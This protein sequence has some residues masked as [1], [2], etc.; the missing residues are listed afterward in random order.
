MSPKKHKCELDLGSD[1]ML[2]K[3]TT[4]LGNCLRNMRKLGQLSKHHPVTATYFGS[5]SAVVAER[6]RQLLE[7]GGRVI[8]PLSVFALIWN[9]IMIIVNLAHM[10]VSTFRL[11]FILR[12]MGKMRIHLADRVL[13]G[14]HALAFLDILVQMNTGYINTKERTTVMVKR[15]TLCHYLRRWFLFDL[16]SSMPLAYFTLKYRYGSR[17][18]LV[19]HILALLRISRIYC[20]HNDLK[21]FLRVFTDSYIV[22]GIVRLAVIFLI[23][24]H[25]CSCIMYLP[26]VV[27]YYWWGVMSKE[28]NYYLRVHGSTDLLLYSWEVRYN[29]AILITLS[30]F[31]GTG[32]TM[33]RSNEPE[34][35]F[36]HAV[37]IVYAAMF[38]IFTLVFLIKSY[39][40]LFGSSLRYHGLM[41]QVEEYMKYRQFPTHLKKRVL[42][43]YQYRYQDRYFKE[44]A[45]LNCLSEELRDEIKLHTCHT[46]VHKVKL[47]EG[48]PPSVVG[49]VL[50]CLHP[51][52]YLS[53]DLVVRAGDIGDCMY[54]IATGTVA[55]YSIKGV[56][57]C[58]LEDGTHFGEVA[59]LMKDSK[60][61]VTVVAVEITQLYRLDARDFNHFVL[62]HP[63]LYSR[64][65]ASVSQRMHE[66]VILDDVLR[67]DRRETTTEQR[68][69]DA[70]ATDST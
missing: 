11:F 34:E 15:Q 35:I 31:F 64:I 14:L 32:F 4:L 61:V 12:P 13:L 5:Y 30:A 55:V 28:Y 68:H 9:T 38:M 44:E 48:V 6:Q 43:F 18:I 19:A 1:S 37:I 39:L 23:T 26:S 56:E 58:H 63:I 47:F 25:W 57:V 66:T 69:S 16:L 29:K 59:L 50:G 20:V 2:P 7:D 49:T 27:Y 17:Y 51:E 42:A 36:C 53:N 41:N 40:T 62:S 24:A 8:H 21:T 45:D 22:H 54:F 67:R 65:E 33:F 10:G 3:E 70:S 52:V 46:L 60:R